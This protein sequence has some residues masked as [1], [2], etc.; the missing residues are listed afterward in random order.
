LVINNIGIRWKTAYLGCN[1]TNANFCKKKIGVKIIITNP[2]S[3][4]A[5]NINTLA[6]PIC[7]QNCMD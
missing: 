1:A 2:I 5:N 7:I 6:T 4:Y 3:K